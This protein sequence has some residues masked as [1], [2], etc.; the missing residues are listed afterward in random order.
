MRR[1]RVKALNRRS[2]SRISNHLARASVRS[3][4][5]CC[6]EL[7]AIY[8][9]TK[10]TGGFS[11]AKPMAPARKG[12]SRSPFWLITKG[13]MR[14]PQRVGNAAVAAGTLAPSATF[15]LIVFGEADP[16][17]QSVAGD[18]RSQLQPL[19][20]HSRIRVSAAEW[21]DSS[22]WAETSVWA[23]VWE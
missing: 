13:G 7:S 12:R 15:L 23:W 11:A 1:L 9:V 8:L 17:L 6:R 19:S 4:R 22:G 21:D 2:D 10:L 5:Q 16:P 18:Q 20:D 3:E 14:C